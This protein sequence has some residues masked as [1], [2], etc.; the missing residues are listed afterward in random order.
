MSWMRLSA[1]LAAAL[2]LGPVPASAGVPVWAAVYDFAGGNG[3]SFPLGLAVDSTGVVY[4]TAGGGTYGQGMVFSLSPPATPGAAWTQTVLWNFGA[5]GDGTQ[6]TNVVIGPGGVLYGTAC[7]GGTS[8]YGTVFSLNPPASPGGSWTETALWNF[9]GGNDGIQPCNGV[10]L[11]SGGVLY[12]TTFQ[13]GSTRLG[14][15]FSLTPPSA[16]GSPWTETILHTFTGGDQ[17][18]Y[19]SY[20]GLAMGRHGALYGLAAEGFFAVGCVFELRPPASPGGA[21]TESVIY[22]FQ[23]GLDGAYPMGTLLVGD[24]GVLYGTTSAGG[25]GDGGTVFSLAP[26]AS[27]GGA[28]SEAILHHFLPELGV[29]TDGAGPQG[30]LWMS[31]NTGALFGTARMGGSSASATNY[32]YGTVFELKPPSS[33][34]DAWKLSTLHDFSGGDGSDPGGLVRGTAGPLF[35]TAGTG[36][37]QN[38]GAVFSLSISE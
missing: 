24:G 1:L 4:G 12:G 29:F 30:A 14:I 27:S 32:G 13:G 37:T 7:N 8:D 26:P 10:I 33:A 11:G 5:Y 38:A 2:G 23:D 35:G 31:K 28:W 21:W 25:P 15:A 6:P 36:G 18:A 34:G 9:A 3:G 16:P 22:N 17:G 19:P 20:G